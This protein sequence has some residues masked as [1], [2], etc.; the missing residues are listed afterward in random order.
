MNCR[1]SAVFALMCFYFVSTAVPSAF[2]QKATER[3]VEKYHPKLSDFRLDADQLIPEV[4][5]S[6]ALIFS[7]SI[8][9]IPGV[10]AVDRFTAPPL[11]VVLQQK[12]GIRDAR[13]G[14]M[15]FDGKPSNGFRK[16]AKERSVWE[17]GSW[18]TYTD[19]RPFSIRTQIVALTQHQGYILTVA[20]KNQSER[21]GHFDVVTIQQPSI[22]APTEWNWN[23]AFKKS[24]TTPVVMQTS[25][26]IVHGNSSGAVA[27]ASG[28]VAIRNFS[29]IPD[30]KE[31]FDPSASVN[32]LRSDEPKTATLL[33]KRLTIQPGRESSVSIVVIA[34]SQAPAAV[35]VAG[36][37]AASPTTAIAQARRDIQSSLEQWF[38][39]LPA[40]TS[41]SPQLLK[42]IATQLRNCF[43]TDGALGRHLFWPPGI[44]PP[45]LTLEQ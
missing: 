2:G 27:I 30:A 3:P 4:D 20:I 34:A 24:V 19:G 14:A 25:D 35:Q 17:P 6:N 31:I 7:G 12:I 13:T 16:T 45:V 21:I 22:A 28:G 23:S 1:I 38:Q 43:T 18:T 9:A 37:L 40:V 5:S 32:Q 29:S 39:R 42:F 26:A 44:R 15:L 8:S 10:S 11:T 36:E 41:S 33:S